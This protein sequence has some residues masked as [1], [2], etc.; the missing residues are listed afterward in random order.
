[1][2]AASD[3]S[4]VAASQASVVDLPP[5]FTL[6]DGERVLWTGRPRVWD[7]WDGDRLTGRVIA[8]AWTMLPASVLVARFTPIL[9]EY[10]EAIPW[11]IV[12]VAAVWVTIAVWGH[13]ITPL[14]QARTRRRTR[15][16]L[17]NLRAVTIE[18]FRSG[19][20]QCRSCFI[21]LAPTASI[22]L[23]SDGWGDVGTGYGVDFKSV[24][25]AQAVHAL[26]VQAIQSAGET[27]SMAARQAVDK[28][29]R[30]EA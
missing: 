14:Q 12:A 9:P 30:D 5:E 28:E 17:T 11:I 3:S 22:V 25:D 8:L 1:M 2:E 19:R 27:R 21:D 26:V 23:G 10:R 7:P 13:T 20:M 24:P 16:V 18:R 15:Y 6:L 4:S 29:R